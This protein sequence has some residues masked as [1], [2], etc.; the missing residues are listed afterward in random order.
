M[1][2]HP[3]WTVFMLMSAANSEHNLGLQTNQA[4]ARLQKLLPNLDLDKII[5]AKGDADLLHDDLIRMETVAL[6]EELVF[7]RA[8]RGETDETDK[9]DKTGETDESPNAEV[10]AM[11]RRNR[12]GLDVDLS[13]GDMEASIRAALGRGQS[14]DS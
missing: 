5:A 10:N 14:E 12:R 1:D 13:G 6:R 3:V 7:E 11:L 2:K 8:Q 4:K 9:T